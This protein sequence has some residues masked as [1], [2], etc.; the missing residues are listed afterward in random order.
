MPCLDCNYTDP[1]DYGTITQGTCPNCGSENYQAQPNPI[2]SEMEMRNMPAPGEEDQ[3]GNPLKEGILADNGWQPGGTSQGTG[4]DE[5]F[6]SVRTAIEIGDSSPGQVYGEHSCLHC[7]ARLF[8]DDDPQG[9]YLICP[10]CGGVNDKIEV[11]HPD[12]TTL[13]QVQG[14]PEYQGSIIDR[15]EVVVPW[16]MASETEFEIEQVIEPGPHTVEVDAPGQPIILQHEDPNVLDD[17]KSRIEA[18][19]RESFL[20]ALAGLAAAA[21]FAA[22]FIMNR[23]M[24]GA[25]AGVGMQLGQN[26]V[27]GGGAQAPAAGPT[28]FRSLEQ[29]SK[30]VQGDRGDFSQEHIPANDT[31]DPEEVDAGEK[32]DG[33][34]QHWEKD[35]S[36]NEVGGTKSPRFAEGSPAIKAFLVSLPDIRHHFDSDES[37]AEDPIVKEI[38]E[39]LE[40]E[41]P[42]YLDDIGEPDDSITEMIHQLFEGT[43]KDE[44]APRVK[45]EAGDDGGDDDYNAND[46]EKESGRVRD[47]AN[48]GL[49][50]VGL[51]KC[52][53]CGHFPTASGAA[54]LVR[55][56]FRG[57]VPHDCPNCGAQQNGLDMSMPGS[58]D[59][60][61]GALIPESVPGAVHPEEEALQSANWPDGG[62]QHC[63]HCGATTKM[64]LGMCPMCGEE[65]TPFNQRSAAGPRTPE[66]FKAVADLLR[67]TGRDEEVATLIDMPEQFEA[68]LAEVMQRQQVTPA[69]GVEQA[70]PPPPMPAQEETPPDAG[71]PMP[72]PPTGIQQMG[73][74][75]QPGPGNW[76]VLSEAKGGDH[77][78]HDHTTAIGLGDDSA[79][80]SDDVSSLTWTDDGGQPLQ[81]G[82]TYQMHSPNYEIPDTIEITDIKPDAIS[83]KLTGE[84]GQAHGAE[85]T[86]EDL[87]L[88]QYTFTPGGA[89]EPEINSVDPEQS[90]DS[91]AGDASPGQQTDISDS[92]GYRQTSVDDE[93]HGDPDLAWLRNNDD[94]ARTAGAQFTMNEQRQFI[95]ERGVARNQDKLDLAH[96]HYDAGY[97]ADDEDSFLFGL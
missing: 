35:F 14:L 70:P 63:A 50:E 32:N 56:T 25:A 67:S 54:A 37:G 97:R 34:N 27:G 39:L 28:P 21:R 17:A 33:D 47:L 23:A 83:V 69:D 36:V 3:G 9:K 74:I 96:T 91:Y 82:Q 18:S 7:G 92:S 94:S 72:A 59:D 40:G 85:I 1:S 16:H 62:I 51:G 31:S 53:N 22:P 81:V 46:I 84:Y 38:H 93:D 57:G 73:A 8:P 87:S 29:L 64:H 15:S 48:R 4:R 44:G 11:A 49:Q 30:I 88:Y 10:E 52:F 12:D 43:K 76:H 77:N 2:N 80:P 95:D 6:A 61:T 13:N 68:E 45:D 55:D 86:K 41:V 66:Q 90:T 26:A 58:F 5:S 65:A 42:G 71:M 19:V 75:V 60:H 89:H 24:G 79:Q 20:P 78:D